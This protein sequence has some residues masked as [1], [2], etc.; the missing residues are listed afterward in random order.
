MQAFSEVPLSGPLTVAQS[1]A[2]LLISAVVALW[3][4]EP[5]HGLHPAV[6]AL[7]GALLMASPRYGS[8]QIGKALKGVPWS[9]L[10]F[11]AATL[12]LGTALVGSGAAQWLAV[13][14]LA[15]VAR[16]GAWAGVGFVIMVVILSTAAHLV[17]QSRSARSAVLIPLVVSLAPQVGVDPVGIAFASTAAAGFCHTL[18]SSAKPVTLFSGIEGVDTYTPK[19]LLRLSAFLAPTMVVLIL[20]FSFIIWPLMGMPVLAK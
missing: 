15:P 18:T 1:R 2:A 16:L 10:L 7:L 8:V 14:L 9:L 19:D 6:V 11:M 3:C 5:L 4:T 12:T 20:L 13:K 17:I